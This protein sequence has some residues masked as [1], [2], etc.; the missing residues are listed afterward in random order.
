MKSLELRISEGVQLVKELQSALDRE[1]GGGTPLTHKAYLSLREIALQWM[2][3][4][5]SL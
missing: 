2:N 5:E 3:Q 4:N 1:R